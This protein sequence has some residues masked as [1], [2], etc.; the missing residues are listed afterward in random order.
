MDYCE[1]LM[2][3]SLAS[4][5]Q[6]PFRPRLNPLIRRAQSRGSSPTARG[7]RTGFLRSKHGTFTTFDAP[8]AGKAAGQGTSA[9]T[10]NPGG[11][12]AG[13]YVDAKGAI[14]GFV[15]ASD[16]T[17]TEFDVEGFGPNAGPQPSDITPGGT[18]D[19]SFHDQNGVVHAF[20]RAPDGTPMRRLPA[21]CVY[22]SATPCGS[23]GD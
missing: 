20:V 11:V 1:L 17:I 13:F 8:D 5:L 7:L 23:S 9:V 12:I 4:T 3:T 14:H 15:R 16:G 6:T 22:R 19:G 21:F 10:I 18:I 2:E